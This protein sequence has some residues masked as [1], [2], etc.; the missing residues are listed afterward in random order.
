VVAPHEAFGEHEPGCIGPF[1]GLFDLIRMPRE[2]LLDE[3][4]LAGVERLDGPRNVELVRQGDVDRVEVSV[5]EERFI[6]AVRALE[7]MLLGVRARPRLVAARDG[8]DIDL[9]A[10]RGCSDDRLVDQP[11]REQ[12]PLDAHG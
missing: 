9:R 12:A 6:A 3:D 5:A 2:G 7:P 8:D 1:E 11:R 10:L 4:V